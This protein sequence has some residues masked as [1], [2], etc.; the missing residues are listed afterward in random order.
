MH[1]N[2]SVV[3]GSQKHINMYSIETTNHYIPHQFMHHRFL[4]ESVNE[5]QAEPCLLFSLSDDCSSDKRMNLTALKTQT[6]G[7]RKE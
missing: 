3:T 1:I 5:K 6:P 4:Q 7:V 2:V